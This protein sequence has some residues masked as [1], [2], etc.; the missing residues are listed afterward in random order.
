MLN[1]NIKNNFNNH[2]LVIYNINMKSNKIML[3][4]MENS[5]KLGTKI[6]KI[7]KIELSGI[8]KT[9]FADGE[10][11]LASKKTVRS[12]DAFIIASTCK[13]T[14]E[15]IMEL[16][17]FIDSLKRASVKTITVALSY[18]GYARQDRKALGRQPITSKLIANL[19][20]T[21]GATKI[22][23]V[24][25]HNPSI[26][27]FFDI[28]LDDLRGQYIFAP[29]IKK[30]GRFTV[31]SPDHGGATRARVLADLLAKTI[32]I[33]IVDKRRI[34]PNESVTVG[35]LGNVKNKNVVIIDDMI[36]TGGTIIKATKIIKEQGAK[37]IIIA[38]TH[39]LFSNGFDEFEKCKEISKVLITDSIQSV[40]N[41]KSKK[42]K[43]VSVADLF[44]KSI[45]ATIN[46]NS[47]TKVYEDI[48]R[49]MQ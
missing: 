47:I 20:E 27:G 22:I 28:P 31:V 7:L 45:K 24:D 33:A 34:G 30:T 10:I 14:N 15:S 37:K 17:I 5:L 40:H 12:R 48:K 11:L 16:L 21:A 39:G 1:I 42:L 41:I 38:A 13:P 32:K 25:L 44:A 26:Q 36:D 6:S 46:S 35:V 9:I 29:E 8:K 2:K 3:F 43:I 23:A 18:Y 19:L 49:K 4:A